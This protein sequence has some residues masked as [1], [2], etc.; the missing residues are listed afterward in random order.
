M[1]TRT[2]YPQPVLLV[3]P[4][5]RRPGKRYTTANNMYVKGFVYKESLPLVQWQNKN[6]KQSQKPSQLPNF[7]IDNTNS[8]I[9]FRSY[10]QFEQYFVS[11]WVHTNDCV[12]EIGAR[13]G[14]VSCTINS[15]LKNKTAHVAVE[16]DFIAVEVLRK[17]RERFGA[18]F[19]ICP[20][21]I[22]AD[23]NMVIIRD[24]ING[25][26][27]T[28]QRAQFNTDDEEVIPTISPAQFWAEFGQPFTVLVI[29]CEGCALQFLKENMA[30]LP[31]LNLIILEADA[32]NICNYKELAD[33]LIDERF[34]MVESIE[35][36]ISNKPKPW[37]ESLQQVWLK[38]KPDQPKWKYTEP[39]FV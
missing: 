35:P 34:G 38:L 17:N 4:F 13:F 6:K 32:C 19:N 9:N 21:A 28:M 10:E 37:Y 23:P 24:S 14:V 27:N 20:A 11:K 31:Y 8:H 12:L 26:G 5:V 22:S 7:L 15:I 29:D 36:S 3:E 25:L 16:P 30:N 33:M 18:K 39:I 2:T 1:K